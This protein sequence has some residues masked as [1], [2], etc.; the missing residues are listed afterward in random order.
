[1]NREITTTKC[2]VEVCRERERKGERER[3][4]E[5][6]TCNTVYLGGTAK[7]PALNALTPRV[8][9]ALPLPRPGIV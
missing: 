9:I 7:V 6:E 8:S 5:R 4:R 2:I 1:M 3:E